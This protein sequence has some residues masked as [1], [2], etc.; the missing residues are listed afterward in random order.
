MAPLGVLVGELV[1]RGKL[2]V[3]GGRS[4]LATESVVF[5]G[6]FCLDSYGQMFF[7]Y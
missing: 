1:C 4:N 7:Y 5:C 2:F 6:C 3:C